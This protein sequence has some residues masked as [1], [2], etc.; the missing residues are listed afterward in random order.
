MSKKNVGAALADTDI[1]DDVPA[2]KPRSKKAKEAAAAAP[3]PG[4]AHPGGKMI[5]I[6]LEENDN[7]PPTGQFFG[8]NGRSYILKPGLKAKVPREIINVLNDATMSVPEVDPAT[9]QVIGYRNR[10]RFPYRVTQQ[11]F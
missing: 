3:V 11:A 5:E 7:I 1:D 6:M 4:P 10:L 2:V 9:N 8:I